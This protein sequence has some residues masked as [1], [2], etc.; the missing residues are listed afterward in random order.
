MGSDPM[1]S[2][3]MGSDPM[4]S[5]PMVRSN[6]FRSNGF[7][8]GFRSNGFRSNG[9]RSNGFRSNG[10]DGFRSNGDPMGSGGTS[11]D[12]VYADNYY[13]VNSSD[14]SQKLYTDGLMSDGGSR[15]DAVDSL[16]V[17]LV[18]HYVWTERILIILQPRGMASVYTRGVDPWDLTISWYDGLR[19]P[20]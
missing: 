18:I 16:S 14:P 4:G 9:F 11:G 6:G 3:P 2:E 8:N 17:E 1:G 15:T 10:S 19:C 12:V 13:I 20:N 7:R 5:D